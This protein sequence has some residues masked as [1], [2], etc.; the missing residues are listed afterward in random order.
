MNWYVLTNQT[1]L[2]F[3]QENILFLSWYYGVDPMISGIMEVFECLGI[4]ESIDYVYL[5]LMFWV[6]LATIWHFV[7]L[8]IDNVKD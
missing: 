2:D 3:K 4:F 8:H 7:I 5:I 1:S 6:Y